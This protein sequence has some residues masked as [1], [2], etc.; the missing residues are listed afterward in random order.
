MKQRDYPIYSIELA[1]QLIAQ[2]YLLVNKKLNKNNPKYYV[3]YF[4]EQEGLKEIVQAFINNSH[5][6]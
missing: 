2:G 5:N 1:H 4:Q 6:K 3:Y